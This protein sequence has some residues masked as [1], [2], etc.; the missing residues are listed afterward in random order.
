MT[1]TR[2]HVYR[3][4]TKGC[5]SIKDA[6]TGKVI[7]HSD[8]LR[9]FDAKFIV[10]KGGQARVRREK[11]KY[12]HAYVS[13]FLNRM[14]TPEG[15]GVG[16][17]VMYNPYRHDTFMVGGSPAQGSYEY[18]SFGEGGAVFAYS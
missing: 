6:K 7:G 12:V 17:R 5:W 9:I 3:N 13:G 2:V 15:S 14:N 16:E 8:G 1:Y 10:Q 4:L 18:V 11:K